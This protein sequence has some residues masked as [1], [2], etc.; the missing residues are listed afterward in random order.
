MAKG[1]NKASKELLANGDSSP[2]SQILVHESF[3]DTEDDEAEIAKLL[4]DADEC[5]TVQPPTIA[6]NGPLGIDLDS[7][8]DFNERASKRK[9]G[10]EMQERGFIDDLIEEHSTALIDQ[11]EKPELDI[12]MVQK[13]AAR[14]MSA[15]DV[16][17]IFCVTRKELQDFIKAKVGL[18]LA[19]FFGFQHGAIKSEI[20]RCQ[21]EAC[22][23]HN[24]P[25]LI[26]MGKNY[27]GQSD[28]PKQEED[29]VTILE[30]PDLGGP[31]D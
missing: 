27:L 22:N 23:K 21:L 26:W 16:A 4:G 14:L 31:K 29:V 9:D 28:T 6:D 25:M 13:M 18:S 12:A 15:D 10:R 19:Q 30:F 3:L 1:K 8:T 20:L 2:D 11:I 17:T 5:I 7:I 24:A